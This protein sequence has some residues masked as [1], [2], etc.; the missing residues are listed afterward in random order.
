MVRAKFLKVRCEK[1]NNEQILFER[2]A[3]RV[4]CLVCN[5]LIATSTGGKARLSSSG[6]VLEVLD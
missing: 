1:C 3:G 6:R 5:E 2:V 4:A